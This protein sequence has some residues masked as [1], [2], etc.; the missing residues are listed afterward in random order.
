M[1]IVTQTD[2][3]TGVTYAYETQHHWDKEKSNPVPSV[4]ELEGLTRL[5][6][7]SFK[8]DIFIMVLLICSANF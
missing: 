3:R 6:V 1:S 8:Q 4:Y 7:K 2:K 5:L